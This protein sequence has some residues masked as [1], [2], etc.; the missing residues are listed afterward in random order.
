MECYLEVLAQ[1]VPCPVVVGAL[2]DL[3]IVLIACAMLII[4]REID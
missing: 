3:A 1:K 4:I 2:V